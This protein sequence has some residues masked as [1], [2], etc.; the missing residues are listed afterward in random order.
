MVVGEDA[1][2]D[3]GDVEPEFGEDVEGAYIML[4]EE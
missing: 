2:E 1:V 4:A 3:E